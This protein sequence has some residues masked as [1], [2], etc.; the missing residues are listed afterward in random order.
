[1]RVPGFWRIAAISMASKLP[2]SMVLLSLLLLVGRDHSYGTAGLAVSSFMIGQGVTAPLRGRL[3]DRYSPRAVLP[4]LLAGYL[5]AT[6]LLVLQVRAHG[7]DTAVV[8]LAAALGATT[9]PVTAMMRSIW[10]TVADARVLATAMA[11]DSTMMGAALVMGPVLAGWLSLSVSGVAPFAVVA[12]LTA[13]V[14]APLVNTPPARSPSRPG[15][16]LGPL[17][18]APLRR[19]MAAD[20]LFVVSLTAVDVVLPIYAQQNHAA[21]YAGLY[22]G[23]MS[24]GSTLGSL[25]LG[26]APAWLSRGPRVSVLLGL[27]AL[28]TGVLALAAR[29]SPQAVLLVCPVAGLLIGSVFGTLRTAGGDLAPDGTVTETMAWLSSLDQAG[30]ALGAAVFAHLAVVNGGSTALLFIP[31]IALLAAATGWRAAASPTASS[32]P[33]S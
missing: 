5:G 9:P 15:H 31:A 2:P 25:A 27:F 28:G 12:V 21:S 16:W 22:L 23:V 1:M 29:I 7:S 18:S 14:V 20:A 4:G 33:D 19:L 17:T 13:G 10:H 26:A 11:L 6:V 24:V 8:A 32:A 3:V 30:G